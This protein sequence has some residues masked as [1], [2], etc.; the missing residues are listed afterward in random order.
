MGDRQLDI[1][2]TGPDWFTIPR[3]VPGRLTAVDFIFFRWD[4]ASLNPDDYTVV[5]E[6]LDTAGPPYRGISKL[7]KS[8]ELPHV[9]YD[10]HARLGVIPHSASLPAFEA[11]LNRGSTYIIPDTK[12]KNGRFQMEL[13]GMRV[14]PGL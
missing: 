13:H 5:V 7:M 3:E 6:V 12:G 9:H 2:A 1:I 4:S 11:E 10:W 8:V 14:P